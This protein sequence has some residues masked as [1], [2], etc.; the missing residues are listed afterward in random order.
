MPKQTERPIKPFKGKFRDIILYEDDELLAV[1]K[2]AGIASLEERNA[3]GT[4]MLEMARRDYESIKLCHRLDKFTTGVLLFAK[5]DESYRNVSMQF[6][7]R[8]IQKEYHTLIRGVVQWEGLVVEAPL[9]TNSKGIVRVDYLDG[10]D[11]ITVFNTQKTF[12]DFTWVKAFPFTGR[13]HQIRVHLAHIACPIIGDTLYG[14]KGLFLSELKRGYKP[15]QE[16]EL[17][18]NAGYILHAFSLN[19]KHPTLNTPLHIEAPLSENLTTCL[20]VLEKYN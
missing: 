16:E 7:D 14:G 6:E 4:G 10:K 13:S 9:S 20:T 12:K 1:N 18:I 8:E 3:P 15:T 2:P 5:S 19:L 17:P 11:C